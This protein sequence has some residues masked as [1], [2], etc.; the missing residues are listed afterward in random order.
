MFHYE[1][2]GS[3]T[4]SPPITP[5]RSLIHPRHHA[6]VPVHGLFTGQS[7]TN[8]PTLVSTFHHLTFLS[9]HHYT[10]AR[11]PFPSPTIINSHTSSQPPHKP[12]HTMPPSA[13]RHR[14][15]SHVC[16]T[17]DGHLTA[18]AENWYEKKIKQ[19]L[20]SRDEARETASDLRRTLVRSDIARNFYA[21]RLFEAEAD[22][23]K[24]RTHLESLEGIVNTHLGPRLGLPLDPVTD[25]AQVNSREKRQERACDFLQFV[26]RI[27]GEGEEWECLLGLLA[28][29]SGGLALEFEFRQRFCEMFR[30]HER[31]V[32]LGEGLVGGL[33]KDEAEVMK[34]ELREY[35]ANQEREW[36]E[37]LGVLGLDAQKLE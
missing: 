21:R 18:K 3:L 16:K 15:S 9:L 17:T 33:E 19:L 32:E 12:T 10:R 26:R 2:I 30:E 24:L 23:E 34:T 7:P 8:P 14:S 1:N 6:H 28:R 31:F 35:V 22:A 29:W 5:G 36:K 13:K 27:V 37:R 11:P 20:A 4:T 25:L